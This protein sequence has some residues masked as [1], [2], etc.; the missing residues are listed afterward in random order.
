MCVCARARACACVRACS[1]RNQTG[2]CAENQY[3]NVDFERMRKN[4]K[5]KTVGSEA[6]NLTGSHDDIYHCQPG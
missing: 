4:M 5:S 6:S 2:C 3:V 1:G